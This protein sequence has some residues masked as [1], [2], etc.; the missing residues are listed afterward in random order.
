M[1]TVL[2]PLVRIACFIEAA[3]LANLISHAES[4][5]AAFDDL[6][7]ASA[8]P[9]PP[10]N[11]AEPLAASTT[12]TNATNAAAAPGIQTATN[13]TMAASNPATSA[14]HTAATN[15]A[16]APD[17]RRDPRHQR[18]TC[19]QERLQEHDQ[20]HEVAHIL[21]EA[22][23]GR[24]QKLGREP[25]LTDATRECLDAASNPDHPLYERACAVLEDA[26]DAINAAKAPGTRSTANTTTAASTPAEST[27]HTAATTNVAAALDARRGSRHGGLQRRTCLQELLREFDQGR[28]V[29]RKYPEELQ[30][31]EQGLDCEPFLDDITRFCLDAASN[32]DHPFYEQA[33]AVVRDANNAANAAK[34]SG[35]QSTTNTTIAAST[36]AASTTNTT[37]NNAAE[38]PTTSTIET[39]A[40][41]ATSAEASSTFVSS[42]NGGGAAKSASGAANTASAPGIPGSASSIEVSTTTVA[43]GASAAAN[44]DKASTITAAPGASG[45][46]NTAFGA[47]PTAF[48]GLNTP[49][50]KQ[51]QQ[52]QPA[53]A[54]CQHEKLPASTH[55]TGL[56]TQCC[57]SFKAQQLVRT[58]KVLHALRLQATLQDSHHMQVARSGQ[59]L[60]CIMGLEDAVG[61]DRHA[62]NPKASA[63]AHDIIQVQGQQLRTRC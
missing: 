16:E 12:S 58:H 25:P 62:R 59:Q 4:A 1:G 55:H 57:E 19:L 32:P 9:T 18:R 48:A 42:C 45:A 29:A 22:M 38:S 35:T 33:C 60:Q 36:P 21:L 24:K 11:T 37:A 44:T 41:V 53:E 28:G 49:S 26:H 54:E 2:L 14:K 7:A 10:T 15:A 27:K 40:S 20:G 50:Q 39:P 47:A 3:P 5:A 34:A 63:S 43:P 8:S 61:A 6:N 51:Q 13:A 31:L 56:T 17:T 46:A 23:Q 52:Q 30:G